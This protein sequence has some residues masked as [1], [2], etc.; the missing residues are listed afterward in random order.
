MN[1]RMA[2]Q[3]PDL[4]RNARNYN[5]QYGLILEA[6]AHELCPDKLG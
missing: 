6:A 5:P 4:A 2:C 1:G 3:Y